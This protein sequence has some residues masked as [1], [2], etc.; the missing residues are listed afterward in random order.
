MS[1]LASQPSQDGQVSISVGCELVKNGFMQLVSRDFQH[2]AKQFRRLG[3]LCNNTATLLEGLNGKGDCQTAKRKS[4]SQ[5]P[6]LKDKGWPH[7][8]GSMEKVQRERLNENGS[9]TA[10]RRSAGLL[11][12]VYTWYVVGLRA[13]RREVPAVSA[14]RPLLLLQE[15]LR[16]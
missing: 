4:K 2:R 7:G 12:S 6:R 1:A 5:W 15:T 10:Q 8:K 11:G 16:N 9:K 13:G 14:S 3:G